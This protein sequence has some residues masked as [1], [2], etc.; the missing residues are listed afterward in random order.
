MTILFFTYRTVSYLMYSVNYLESKNINQSL[1]TV[2]HIIEPI[3][4]IEDSKN[5]T[6]INFLHGNRYHFSASLHVFR[7]IGLIFMVTQESDNH[8]KK[9]IL[10]STNSITFGR[11]SQKL[12]II[13]SML[14]FFF[15]FRN[16][17]KKHFQMFGSKV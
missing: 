15:Y 14:C 5:Y 6:D 11:F 10:R 4:L 17:D 16:T 1:Q 12:R 8:K 2:P 3:T 9:K 7:T 13:N